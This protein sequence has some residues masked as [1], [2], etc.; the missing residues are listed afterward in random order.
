MTDRRAFLT[1]ALMAPVAIATPA[2]AASTAHDPHWKALLAEMARSNKA[3][4][5]ASAGTDE[6]Y[7]R[8]FAMRPKLR[9][10]R[11]RANGKDS[12]G[13]HLV[14]AAAY[15]AERRAA[16]EEFEQADVD[17]R[18]ISGYGEREIV[19]A[20]SLDALT[21]SIK[22]IIAYPSRDPDII[23]FKLRL[24]VKEYGDDSGDLTPLL[25]SI[26]GGEA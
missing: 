7:D 10:V 11:L 22:A 4:D 5:V 9:E 23:A 24:I 1:A 16:Q 6:A 13:N 17:A 2:L 12:D 19:Q 18:R 3:H 20:S 21:A 25:A 15:N 14:D 8:Y 26:A